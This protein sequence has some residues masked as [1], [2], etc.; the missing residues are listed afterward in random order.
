[1]S[2]RLK[3]LKD[4][5]MVIT[6]ASSGIGLTTARLA[7][8][9]G[10]CLV[11][12]ARNED[13]LQHLADEVRL[14]GGEAV[15]VVADVGKEE[16]VRRIAEVALDRFGGFDTW[17]NNAGVGI[18]GKL[19]DISTEDSRRLFDTNFW[20]TVYGSLEAAR[21][22]R[23]KEGP[24]GGAII[25]VGSEVSDRAV[26]LIGMY[27]ASKHAVKG[28]TD[29]LRMELEKEKAPISVTLVKPSAIDT[30]FPNHARTYM[31]EEP[32]LPA[33]RYA[34]EIPAQVILHCAVT[35]ERDM[36]AGGSAKLH[37]VQGTLMPR[38]V[39]WMMEWL[40]FDK[41]KSGKPADRSDDAL[42]RPTTG[43][44]ARGKSKG[45]VRETSAYTKASMHPL[46]TG[47]AL[48]GTGLALAAL[49]ARA[50]SGNG[51]E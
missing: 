43:M 28:F 23:Q 26:P 33:P 19:L 11:L 45:R 46:L 29:A 35:P 44:Q 27:S 36:F 24:Y 38:I 2:V 25:N 13:A 18:Y 42:D 4:Q 16:D 6:G 31:D 12:A 32:T 47:A 9:E 14:E 15:H 22:L 37:S 51:N 21:H 8:R 39:D 10:A 3:K 7:A 48:V 41:Q 17:V 50:R 40:Y 1:M 49:F 34:P 5:V 20:G 30:P